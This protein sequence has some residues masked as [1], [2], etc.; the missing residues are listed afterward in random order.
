[1]ISIDCKNGIVFGR[2][3]EQSAQKSAITSSLPIITKQK[4][5]IFAKNDYTIKC[6]FL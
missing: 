2:K 6:H 1:V 5:D 4:W 3:S